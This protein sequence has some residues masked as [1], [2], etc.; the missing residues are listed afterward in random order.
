MVSWVVV[1][2]K[3]WQTGFPFDT[4]AGFIPFALSMILSGRKICILKTHLFKE[5][6]LVSLFC[7]CWYCGY[8]RYLLSHN[9]YQN[10]EAWSTCITS[11]VLWSGV[12]ACTAEFSASGTLTHQVVSN[13]TQGCH[14]GCSAGVQPQWIQGNSKGRWRGILERII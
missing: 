12:W 1:T 4:L 11:H 5:V 6:R 7:I 13:V 8:I 9:C 3:C 14:W 2:W 10:L